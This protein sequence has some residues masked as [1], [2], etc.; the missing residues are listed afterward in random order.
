MKRLGLMVCLLSVFGALPALASPLHIV[1]AKPGAPPRPFFVI[2]LSGDGGWGKM[3]QEEADRLAAAGAPIVGVSTLR[4]YAHRRTSAEAAAFVAS[5][6]AQY[7]AQFGRTHFVLVGF[8]FGAG[9]APF[10]VNALPPAIREQL[11]LTALLSPGV[12]ADMEVGPTSWLNLESGPQVAPEIARMA[13]ARVLCI[14]DVGVFQDVC[15]P[16]STPTLTALRLGGG[17]VLHNQYD[18]IARAILA[19]AR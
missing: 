9:V 14:G 4:Y 15:P 10:I 19:A 5:L 17:H 16:A 3:E 6:A 2:W 13:P 18:A 7:G 8:S 11:L 1:P 12:R